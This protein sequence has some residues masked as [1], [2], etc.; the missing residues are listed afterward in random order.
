MVAMLMQALERRPGHSVG[1]G[2][3]VM[4]VRPEL[5]VL[6]TEHRIPFEPVN[7]QQ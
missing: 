2:G 5:L 1:A 3:L 6:H 4:H 7:K